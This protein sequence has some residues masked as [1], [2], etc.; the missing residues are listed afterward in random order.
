[1]IDWKRKLT[2]RK[3]WAAIC[4]LV[5]NLV[6]YFGGSQE[7]AVQVTAIIMAGASVIAYIIG[8]GLVDAAGAGLIDYTYEVEEQPPNEEE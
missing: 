6:I 1:M 3:L 8:E 5:T 2:S 4:A 7:T